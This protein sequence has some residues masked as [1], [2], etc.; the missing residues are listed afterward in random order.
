MSGSHLWRHDSI[1]NDGS[2]C[3]VRHKDP[4]LDHSLDGG[5]TGGPA[6]SS[7]EMGHVVALVVAVATAS[8]AGLLRRPDMHLDLVGS[9]AVF[10]LFNLPTLPQGRS[11]LIV[12]L[13]AATGTKSP[14]T[15]SCATTYSQR[16][17]GT[18]LPG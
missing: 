5:D 1:D 6:A 18:H 17:R 10:G 3:G 7:R 15:T 8:L 11:H 12:P 13:D 9:K 14:T 16:S 4:P 2:L